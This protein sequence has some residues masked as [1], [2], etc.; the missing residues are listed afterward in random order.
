MSKEKF[1]VN[2]LFCVVNPNNQAIIIAFDIKNG[3]RL[4]TPFI[5]LL[6]LPFFLRVF[7]SLCFPKKP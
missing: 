1:V 2:G 4:A 6:P 5:F 7:V 3:I